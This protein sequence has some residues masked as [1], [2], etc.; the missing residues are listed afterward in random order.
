MAHV[1]CFMEIRKD[2]DC[3]SLTYVTYSS[4]RTLSTVATGRH[5]GMLPSPT[6]EFNSV[7]GYAVKRELDNVVLAV[8]QLDRLQLRADR[9]ILCYS[10]QKVDER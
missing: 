3:F 4:L 8:S 5:S 9:I 10:H 2:I 7:L 6:T 1:S